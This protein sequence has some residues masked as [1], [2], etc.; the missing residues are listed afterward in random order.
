METSQLMIISWQGV[1]AA[2]SINRRY[3]PET[4]LW[5]VV[6]C[7]TYRPILKD[8]DMK[9]VFEATATWALNPTRLYSQ[10]MGRSRVH[11]LNQLPQG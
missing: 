3:L 5:L 1:R 2:E 9:G 7:T 10:G 4:D 11:A 8:A 6:V